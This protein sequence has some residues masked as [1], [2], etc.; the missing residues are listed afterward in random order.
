MKKSE[1]AKLFAII[2]AAFPNMQVTDAMTEIW[3]ELLGDVDFDVA[4]IAV[5]KL[6]LESSYPP[7]IADV[8]KQ[9]V[10]I[11]SPRQIDPAEAWGEVLNAVHRYGY[12]RQEEALASMSPLVAKA[13]RYM[14]W[15][16]ICMSEEPSVIRGQFMRIFQ[17]LQEREKQE[18]LLPAKLKNDI[19]KIAEKYS[20]EAIEAQNDREKSK[21]E[22]IPIHLPRP[23][24]TDNFEK[25]NLRAL[26]GR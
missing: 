10:S 1:I 14:G 24:T 8:R 5:K 2:T 15:Q 19:Q 6:L 20:I 17:Q 11:M 18:A 22:K 9:V 4:Q 25:G 7:T 16:E 12:Y 23:K 3:Y 21:R 13:V 26:I